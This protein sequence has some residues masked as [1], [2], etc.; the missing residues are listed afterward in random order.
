MLYYNQKNHGAAGSISGRNSHKWVN[1]ILQDRY[2]L[3][4]YSQFDEHVRG[5]I[6]AEEQAQ[7]KLQAEAA[8]KRLKIYNRQKKVVLPALWGS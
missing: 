4:E 6:K 2:T 5:K 1:F 3:V 8:A 7:K